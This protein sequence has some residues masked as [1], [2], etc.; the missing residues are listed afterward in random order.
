VKVMERKKRKQTTV[1][2]DRAL[3]DLCKQV[4]NKY[5]YKLALM[6]IRNVSDL[7]EVSLLYFLEH[8]L[9]INPTEFIEK[10]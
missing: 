5:E 4:I 8:E 1:T 6:R 3:Y 9:K 10:E 7:F 2:V